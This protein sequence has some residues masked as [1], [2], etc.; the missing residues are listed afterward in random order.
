MLKLKR[1]LNTNDRLDL[2]IDKGTQ[3]L[4]L[5]WGDG[6]IQAYSSVFYTD[7]KVFKYTMLLNSKINPPKNLIQMKADKT[8]VEYDFRVNYVTI[9]WIF[10]E[11]INYQSNYFFFEVSCTI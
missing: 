10:I 8:L 6:L 9:F 3:R 7:N 5:L 4:V 11:L 2:E 1:K